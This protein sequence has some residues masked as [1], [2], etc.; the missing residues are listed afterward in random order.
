MKKGL[1]GYI[2]LILMITGTIMFVKNYDGTNDGQSEEDL[3]AAI[4]KS[5]D[6]TKKEKKKVEE[7]LT[8][9]SIELQNNGFKQVG[10]G[11]SLDDRQV[12]IQVPDEKFLKDNRS[13][14]ENIILKVAK[15]SELQDF[16]VD[17]RILDQYIQ[18]SEEE[19]ELNESISKET[20]K[21]SDILRAKGFKNYSISF[22][23]QNEI[24]IE[25]TEADLA[26]K[27]ALE[28]HIADT[29]Y[30][31]TKQNF[32]V[33]IQKKSENQIRD[34]EWQPIFTSI[35]DETKKEFDEY[36]GFAYSF[37]PEP[38]QIIIKTNLEKP[39]WFW[40]SDE[41]VKQITKYVEKII[42]LKREELSI[43][44]IPYEIIIRDKHNKKMN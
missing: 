41:Q 1:I 21:I 16:K 15:E 6:E 18:L 26:K 38:L 23:P 14:I 19:L 31:K 44:E 4:Q 42:E 30:I 12:D 11:F 24:I 22:Q 9:G 25:G 33:N 39:K 29:I 8:K 3:E 10:L 35:M 37:H 17:Y 32:T 20:L 5:M 28:K 27:E 2:F 7:F 13:N 43:K 34:Q 40:N 36:R